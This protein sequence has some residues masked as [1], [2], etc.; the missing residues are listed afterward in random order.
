[1]VEVIML[2][3]ID[4]LTASRV[5]GKADNLGQLISG[6]FQVPPGA[7]VPVEVYERFLD[8]NGLRPHIEAILASPDLQGVKS[9][10]PYCR[11]EVVDLYCK[12]GF[13]TEI[14]GHVFMRKDGKA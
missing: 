5:G 13:S 9:F 1:M 3:S 2:D 12:F 7:V 6:G 11:P 4:A 8:K 14:G 10:E